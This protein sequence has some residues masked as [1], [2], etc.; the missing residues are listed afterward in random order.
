MCLRLG[1]EKPSFSNTPPRFGRFGSSIIVESDVVQFVKLVVHFPYCE[2]D[3]RGRAILHAEVTERRSLAP[4][5]GMITP[6]VS[7]AC[8]HDS[9]TVTLF[10][11]GDFRQQHSL[12][13]MFYR[14]LP[15]Y[16]AEG[17]L[18]KEVTFAALL[19]E[20]SLYKG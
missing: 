20:T 19:G 7:A 3:W 6:V 16:F 4:V 12:R 17:L 14:D 11:G 8:G 18:H 2:A 5:K 9:Y 1:H 13:R 15:R 10:H